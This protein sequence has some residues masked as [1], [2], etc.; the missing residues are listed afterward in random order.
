MSAFLTLDGLSYKTPDGHP[1]FDDLTLAFGAERTGLMGRNGVGKTT[2]IRLMLGEIAPAAG[3]VAVRGRIGVLRQALAPPPG[4]SV[5]QVLGLADALA[6]LDRIE[7][8]EGTEADFNDADWT[9]PS[10]LEAGLTQVGLPGLDPLRPAGELSGGEATRA[11]LAGLLAQEPDLLLLDEPT[12][13]LDTEARALI[14]QV[15]AGW[16]GGAVVVSH[17]RA[18]LREMDRIV[19]LTSL[20]AK[21]YGGG[22]DLYAE[23]KAQAEAAAVRDL[24]DAERTLARVERESQV[25][26]ERKARRDAAGRKFAAKRSEPKILLGGM[27]ERAENSGAREGQVAERLREQAGAE[28]AE[29][30]GRVERLRRLA[31]ELPPSGLA[32]GKTVL[33]FDDVSFAHPGAAPA[34]SGLSFRLTGPERVAVTGPNGAGK[35]T[36]IRLAVGDLAPG[37]GRITHGARAALLDQKTAMLQ[38]GETL[39]QAFQRLN[40]GATRN[41]AHAALARFLFRNTAAEKQIAALS[42]GERL[43]AAMACVLMSETPPQLLVLDEPTNHLDLDSIAAVEAAL[44]SY[45]GALLVVSHDPDFLQAIGVEREVELRPPHRP[46]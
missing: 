17:D 25:A 29:A 32:S 42:G 5:A 18:L 2:L 20:G 23:R 22:Y 15:L 7:A 21:V 45:D 24:A 33:A 41:D 34:L 3:A 14:A 46:G 4:A 6:R 37:S 10:R 12:N 11:A 38:A 44:R 1:L 27:A 16:K 8:G 39:V 13:N 28:L 43:R 36:L 9:L 19:E 35:T 31:F 40:P 30:Q 26:R